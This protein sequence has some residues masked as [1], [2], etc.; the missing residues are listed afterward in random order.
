MWSADPSPINAIRYNLRHYFYSHKYL[1]TKIFRQQDPTQLGDI[2][3][4]RY[5][6]QPTLSGP[7]PEPFLSRYSSRKLTLYMRSLK[8]RL[9]ISGSSACGPRRHSPQQ[10]D[11]RRRHILLLRCRET[12]ER[13]QIASL[14]PWAYQP[15]RVMLSE[16]NYRLSLKRVDRHAPRLRLAVLGTVVEPAHE[17]A[18]HEH[19]LP[20]QHQQIGQA[21]QTC[22]SVAGT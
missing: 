17:V 1:K 11:W 18:V 7:R 12:V 19:L 21:S 14:V 6:S 22:P 20:Q 9:V 13:F 2:F 10:N 5:R 8:A 3:N 15:P 4:L 16:F